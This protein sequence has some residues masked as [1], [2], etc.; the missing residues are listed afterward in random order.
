MRPGDE[1][2]TV[3]PLL[4]MSHESAPST[5]MILPGVCL[6]MNVPHLVIPVGTRINAG[7]RHSRSDARDAIVCDSIKEQLNG[8]S[9]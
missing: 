2:G 6:N 8:N 3:G 7:W 1:R 9:K 4:G 5:D